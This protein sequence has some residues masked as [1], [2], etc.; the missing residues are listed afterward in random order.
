M[1]DRKVY[2]EMT[3]HHKSFTSK[4]AIV[5]ID[6]ETCEEYIDTYMAVAKQ[7]ICYQLGLKED[8][9]DVI[10]QR[11]LGSEVIFID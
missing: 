11:F 7:K 3:V 4:T 6:T 2:V 9:V 10:D 5:C 1:Q 8:E